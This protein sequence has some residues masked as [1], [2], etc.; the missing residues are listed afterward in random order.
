MRLSALS[1]A[2]QHAFDAARFSAA[3]QAGHG[4]AILTQI[5]EELGI[6]FDSRLGDINVS[7]YSLQG[8]AKLALDAQPELVTVNNAGIPAFLSNYLDPKLIEVLV[9]PMK[10]AEIAGETQ[11]GDWTTT[12][13]T[14]PVIESTG[15]VSSY[16]DFSNNGSV[17]VNANF[18]QRQS[19][20]YQTFTQWG[21]KELA[22]AAL[23]RIDWAARVNVA[24]VLILNKYQN[25]TYFFGVAGLQNYGMLN[26]PSL[27][28]PI[29]PSDPGGWNADSAEDIYGDVVRLF[30]QLQTQANG[31]ID[32]DAS[33]CMALSPTNSVNLN[34]TNQFNVNVYDQIKKNFPN[35]RVETAPEYLTDSGELVQLIVDEVEGQETWTTAFTEKLRAH[36]MVI[37][38][39]SFKQKKSQ[40]TYGTI[41]FR[42]VYIAQML[43]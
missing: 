31:T 21:E 37:D 29:I 11:K 1:A 5:C 27:S 26:D 22:V 18:P 36:A 2:E 4:P 17:E 15:E 43:G 19:Y 12:V 25:Q 16:G 13:S 41:I 24:S 20:H 40:G 9:S 3:V 30:K 32:Q 38:T 8:Q 23:A 42:P 39:S 6:A 33:M 10:G 35:I 34:K 28:A 7:P 14:F